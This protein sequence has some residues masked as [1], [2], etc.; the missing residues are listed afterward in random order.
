MNVLNACG[1]KRAFG[2]HMQVSVIA[3]ALLVSMARENNTLTK[4][5][6]VACECVCMI[7]SIIGFVQQ[8]PHTFTSSSSCPYNPTT[9]PEG[10]VFSLPIPSPILY[11]NLKKFIEQELWSSIGYTWFIAQ[12]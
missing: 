7:S 9:K 8:K 10:N 2:H 11:G 5:F 4:L 6:K 12:D 1:G 3:L